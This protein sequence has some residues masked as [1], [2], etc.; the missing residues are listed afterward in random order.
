MSSSSSAAAD[1]TSPFPDDDPGDGDGVLSQEDIFSNRRLKKQRQR[2]H[3]KKLLKV[4][5]AV[6]P[7]RS[8]RSSSR[9]AE[10]DKIFSSGGGGGMDDD[11]DDDDDDGD[12][13]FDSSGMPFVEEDFGS[14]GYRAPPASR[15]RFGIDDDVDEDEEEWDDDD[16]GKGKVSPS[17]TTSYSS[18]TSRRI[19]Y[20][21]KGKEEDD[22]D[23]EDDEYDFVLDP[24]YSPYSSSSSS[25][26]SES[27]G[28]SYGSRPLQV[29]FK[30]IDL[31]IQQKEVDVTSST[32]HVIWSPTEKGSGYR[33]PLLSVG[34]SSRAGNSAKL[35]Q[36]R[37]REMAMA[38]CFRVKATRT[39]MFMW[40]VSRGYPSV[41]LLN[42]KVPIQCHVYDPS[43]VREMRSYGSSASR[44]G[45]Y[46]FEANPQSTFPYREIRVIV[47]AESVA[48]AQHI[49]SDYVKEFLP[50]FTSVK[51]WRGP[52]ELFSVTVQG[53][54]V[55][56]S[57]SLFQK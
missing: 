35:V 26:H 48:A 29:K 57:R 9:L 42:Y 36:S 3:R 12:D 28:D 20:R 46:I 41:T 50:R 18:S 55:V 37:D 15:D 8:T 23:E 17:H 13:A 44:L 54:D 19:I 34:M 53:S 39:E 16:K 31:R 2:R 5:K 38:Q 7:R 45:I 14:S 22:D 52:R 51:M 6:P 4:K 49:Y 21:D 40:T 32:V 24:N 43:L 11:D 10:Q 56:F 30:A 1:F 33:N 25:S 47:T 27:R